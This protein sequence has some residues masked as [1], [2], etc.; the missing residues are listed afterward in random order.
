MTSVQNTTVEIPAAAHKAL[1]EATS[2]AT[3]IS[4][5]GSARRSKRLCGTEKENAEPSA[6]KK[7][8]KA[9]VDDKAE[10]ETEVGVEEKDEEIVEAEKEEEKEKDFKVPVEEQ[11]TEEEKVR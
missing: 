11:P 7:V 3:L 2:D 9:K 6:A 8:K 4:P 10:T 5:P 1:K